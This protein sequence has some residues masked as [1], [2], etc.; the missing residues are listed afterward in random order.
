MTVDE[1]IPHEIS[2]LNVGTEVKRTLLE[3]LKNSPAFCRSNRSRHPK[4]DDIRLVRRMGGPAMRR[5]QSGRMI[6]I[7]TAT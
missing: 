1:S 6:C 7:T 3:T 5:T 4:A 2:D